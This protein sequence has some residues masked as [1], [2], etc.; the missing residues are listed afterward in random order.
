[1]TDQKPALLCQWGQ[2][3]TNDGKI[4]WRCRNPGCRRTLDLRPEFEPPAAECRVALRA[5]LRTQDETRRAENAA[6]R[7]EV[8]AAKAAEVQEAAARLA[9][10]T[11][12]PSLLEKAKHYAAALLRWAKAGWPRRTAEEVAA[13]VAT[14]ESCDHYD[15]QKQACGKCGCRVSCKG[16]AIRNK[17]KMRTEECP[18]GKWAK[19]K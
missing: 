10:E 7:E 1:M 17:A 14:C 3:G 5:R 18:E 9:E 2:D 6:V 11:G 16:L 8:Q 19:L 15:H 13:C 4:R 12:D